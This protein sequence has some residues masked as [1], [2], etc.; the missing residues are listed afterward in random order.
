VNSFRRKQETP[1]E[2]GVQDRPLRGGLTAALSGGKI[3]MNFKII[4]RA[5][6]LLLL[7]AGCSM[8]TSTNDD[9]DLLDVFQ[10]QFQSTPIPCANTNENCICYSLGSLNPMLPLRYTKYQFCATKI[11]AGHLVEA[12]FTS[13]DEAGNK[14][15]EGHFLNK[16]M[17]GQWV[18]WHPNGIKAGEGNYRDGKEIGP[19]TT[20]H[21]NGQIAVQGYH[22]DE[23]NFD[24][25]MLYWD[26]TGKLTKK[27]IW[28]NGKLISRQEIKP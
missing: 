12:A 16:K 15:D 17:N 28:N 26:K 18:S 21:D 14:V 9:K 10:K 2:P 6:P 1:G 24:G 4:M 3:E 20:W 25:E 19:F 23:G 11:E 13:W 7:L 8:I 27:L 5:F 22:N